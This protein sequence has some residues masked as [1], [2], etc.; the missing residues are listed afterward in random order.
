MNKLVTREDLIKYLRGI[1]MGHITPEMNHWGLCCVIES[2]SDWDSCAGRTWRK[3][4]KVF[5]QYP[6]YS[7]RKPYP[8]PAP[9][10]GIFTKFL[11]RI[12]CKPATSDPENMYH[13]TENKYKGAYGR[14]RRHFAGWCADYIVKNL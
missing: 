1:Q 9:R 7:G 6:K 14:N 3:V 5:A 2:L 13:H 10:Y 12:V 4:R 8:V 11:R